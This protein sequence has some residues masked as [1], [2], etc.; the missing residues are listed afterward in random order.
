MGIDPP[1]YVVRREVLDK[2]EAQRGYGAFEGDLYGVG[3]L[4]GGKRVA[5]GW[6]WGQGRELWGRSMGT[7]FRIFEDVLRWLCWRCGTSPE[8]SMVQ[9]LFENGITDRY[10]Q[11]VT[12]FWNCSSG[13][14][15]SLGKRYFLDGCRGIMPLMVMIRF[16]N[17]VPVAEQHSIIG[18]SQW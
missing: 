13:R 3:E 15:G 9:R 8:T 17:R 7:W 5:R 14:V 4:L 12:V 16:S 11:Q 2:G 10:C 18:V 1:D 6:R